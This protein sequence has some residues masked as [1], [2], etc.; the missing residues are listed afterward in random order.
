[1]SMPVSIAQPP[2]IVTAQPKANIVET[3]EPAAAKKIKAE[4]SAKTDKKNDPMKLQNSP[5][6]VVTPPQD[7][8]KFSINDEIKEKQENVKDLLSSSPLAS[9]SLAGGSNK[10]GHFFRNLLVLGAGIAG[11]IFAVK[12]FKLSNVASGSVSTLTDLKSHLSDIVNISKKG[13]LKPINVKKAS[14]RLID[15]SSDTIKETLSTTRKLVTEARN[16]EGKTPKIIIKLKETAGE[17]QKA[18][19]KAFG[20]NNIDSLSDT[21][22][23]DIEYI[24]IEYV[25][26]DK[27]STEVIVNTIKSKFIDSSKPQADGWDKAVKFF[28]D[29]LGD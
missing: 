22:L 14:V 17:S 3:N 26:S 9:S 6:G 15:E 28:K 18:I 10:G 12:K 27:K 20:E 24:N 1:M 29:F 5:V 7:T 25:S 21:A 4:D 13:T 2:Q 16:I 8:Y 19:K 23:K 11:T